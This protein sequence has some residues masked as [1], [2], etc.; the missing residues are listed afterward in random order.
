[1][2]DLILPLI[3]LLPHT[4]TP[5]QGSLETVPIELQAIMQVESHGGVDLDHK[6]VKVG[7]N[8]GT[9]AYGRF[10]LMP[11]TIRDTIAK[12]SSLVIY[13]NILMVDP[14]EIHIFMDK[15]RQLEILV[16]KSIY[17]KLWKRYRGDLGKIFY[18][19]RWGSVPEGLSD[20]EIAR[21]GYVIRAMKAYNNIRLR[22]K[23]H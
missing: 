14:H 7:L 23:P 1:M 20:E 8:R 3:F 21:N 10:G 17:K 12:D 18:S 15:N 5:L 19:W 4:T 11:L 22:K 2:I 6:L 16:A 13:R 9:V